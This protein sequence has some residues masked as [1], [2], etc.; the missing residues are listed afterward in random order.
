LEPAGGRPGGRSVRSS[1]KARAVST[2]QVASPKGLPRL[3]D[4]RNA[5]SSAGVSGRFT[6]STQA[7][8]HGTGQSD[9]TAR[10]FSD[11]RSRRHKLDHRQCSAL[12]TRT[13]PEL[14]ERV[15]TQ[16]VA[17]HVAENIQ[18][19]SILLDRKALEPAP[20]DFAQGRL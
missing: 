14:V 20:F 16:G 18:Q 10:C 19:V 17:L 2:T 15:G 13:C 4:R 11:P 9:S 6:C 7:L 12:C 5:S 1:R 8:G 3:A